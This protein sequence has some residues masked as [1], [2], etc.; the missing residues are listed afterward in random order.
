MGSY[1]TLA[2]G[3]GFSPIL[4]LYPGI[5]FWLTAL[6]GFLEDGTPGFSNTASGLG[7]VEAYLGPAEA[8]F[9]DLFDPSPLAT[10]TIFVLF[11]FF[12]RGSGGSVRA[13]PVALSSPVPP[14]ELSFSR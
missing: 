3:T 14:V 12:P 9:S 13:D 1:F 10:G 2:G 7:L 11:E 8:A 5:G 4:K 6:T